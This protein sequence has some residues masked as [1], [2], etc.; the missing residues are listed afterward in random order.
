MERNEEARPKS[1]WTKAELLDERDR[2]NRRIRDLEDKTVRAQDDRTN[3]QRRVD[4]LRGL[5]ANMQR[6]LDQ[7][8]G[9][10]GA[11]IDDANVTAET[12]KKE[13]KE[14]ATTR[15][16]YAI[17]ERLIYTTDRGKLNDRLWYDV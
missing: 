2:L 9:Y 7:A 8:H 3:A 17:A 15:N 1:A 13:S 5:C 12:H 10:I 16:V 11:I 6:D 4:T 14:A